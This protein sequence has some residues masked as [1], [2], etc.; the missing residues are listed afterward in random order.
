MIN[1]EN[2]YKKSEYLIAYAVFII[3]G[4]NY[5]LL[6]LMHVDR[7]I[8]EINRYICLII[9]ILNLI[10]KKF[11]L[12][13]FLFLFLFLILFGFVSNGNSLL[14]G[15]YFSIIFS[16]IFFDLNSMSLLKIQ[17]KCLTLIFIFWIFSLVSGIST[18]EL[19]LD[20]YAAELGDANQERLRYT[21]GFGNP[22]EAAS[23]VTSF[24]LMG[25]VA[26][27]NRMLPFIF[28]LSTSIIVYFYTD[29]R[30]LILAVIFFILFKHFYNFNFKNSNLL[31][32]FTLAV[33]LAPFLIT[34]ASSYIINKYPFFDVLFSY[35]LIRVSNYFLEFSAFNILFGGASAPLVAIDNSFALLMGL[36]GLSLSLLVI[37]FTYRASLSSN[38]VNGANL[39]AFILSFWCYSFFESSMLRP[40]LLAGLIFWHLLAAGCSTKM[41]ES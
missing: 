13:K 7:Y 34:L 27:S 18:N 12:N 30:A 1:I 6:N 37:F 25:F 15:F 38:N 19:N 21:L 9:I 10:F 5:F 16:L 11:K 28:Y 2:N 26:S 17:L 40:E 4:L 33:I 39:Y 29:S 20:N 22:N 32:L 24:V 8:V 14:M 41:A 23:I 36:G 35:R 31:K 3:L